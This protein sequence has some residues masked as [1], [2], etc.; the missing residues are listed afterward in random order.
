MK[1]QLACV[2]FVIGL[3]LLAV[4]CQ[5]ETTGQEMATV[6]PDS[7]P[8]EPSRT[9]PEEASPAPEATATQRPSASG[10]R[11]KLEIPTSL[12][13]G[14]P[15]NIQ[16]F[17]VN[18]TENDLYILNWFTPLEGLGGD[19][20]RVTRDGQRVRYQ[21]PLASRGDPTPEAYTRIKAGEM[22]SAEVD[23]SPAYDFTM[24]GTYTIEFVSPTSS[25]VADTEAGMAQ[26][27]DELGPVDIPSNEVSVMIGAE[28]SSAGERSAA[29]DVLLRYFSSLNQ[30]QYAEAAALYGN[31]YEVL[32]D[33]NPT[34]DPDDLAGLLEAGCTI[35]GLQCL[36]VRST[37]PL[38]SAAP[39]TYTF[40][41]QFENPDGS[42]FVLNPEGD[43]GESGAPWSLFEYTV[44]QA[45]GGF[46]VQDLPVSVP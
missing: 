16:F 12:P 30:G 19:I 6:T 29:R 32:M 5:G 17:L 15:V 38:A 8:P 22:A 7:A 18:E 20:F 35:N 42:L 41:V 45:D 25:H 2:F 34:A 14:G 1:K 26:S 3:L 9:S 13:L 33:W 36:S 4:S 44:V 10:L 31:G 39:N 40:A 46:L 27:Q 37:A 21:G 24:P 23:L 28:E 11:A 43:W